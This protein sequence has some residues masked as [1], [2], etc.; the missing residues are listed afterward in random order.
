MLFLMIGVTIA[1]FK[2]M[3]NSPD[4]KDKLII[5]VSGGSIRD[6]H[7]FKSHVGITSREHDLFGSLQIIIFTS[8]SDTGLNS[9]R[10]AFWFRVVSMLTCLCASTPTLRPSSE[11]LIF[12][13][14][15]GRN[16]QKNCSICHNRYKP[17]RD[18]P[19]FVKQAI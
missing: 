14:Y 18:P 2:D 19:P 4:F 3:G 7:C 12:T 16:Q 15:P 10:T 17:V 9:V 5:A 8:S 6:I 11:C 13:F 1:C